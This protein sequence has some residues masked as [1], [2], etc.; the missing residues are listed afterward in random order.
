MATTDSSATLN[1][2]WTDKKDSYRPAGEVIRTRDYEVVELPGDAIPKA[3]VQ[4]HHYSGTYPSAMRRFGLYR[5]GELTGV[6]VWSY[7]FANVCKVAFPQLQSA[8]VLEL[9]RFVLKDE[10]PGNGETWFLGQ[11]VPALRASGVQGLLSF[12]DP[13]PRKVGSYTVFGGHVGTIYQAFNGRYVGR[14]TSATLR[15]FEDGKVFN[16]ANCQK[17]RKLKKGWEYAVRQLEDAGAP[18]L[19]DTSDSAR[20]LREVALPAVTRPVRHPGNLRYVWGLN[21]RVRKTLDAR[22]LPFVKTPDVLAN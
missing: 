19:G 18:S 1:Q 20:W 12:A 16:N 17:I 21:K 2:R 3:F 5:H 15:M 7:V 10:V 22:A 6:A 11:M 4:Q 14:A 9:S 13:M 8:D